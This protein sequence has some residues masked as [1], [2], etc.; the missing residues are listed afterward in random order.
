ML[1]FPKALFA[2]PGLPSAPRDGFGQ[3]IADDLRFLLRFRRCR[4]TPAAWGAPSPDEARHYD[5]HPV[6]GRFADATL[7]V[8]RV[9]GRLWVVRERDYFG[10]PDPPRFAF[11]ALDPNGGRVWA[12]ADFGNWPDPWT[13][14]A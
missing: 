6:L 2:R 8:T 14:D 7:A 3:G 13:L 5:G 4:H 10:W 12:A 9:G 11:F 1:R